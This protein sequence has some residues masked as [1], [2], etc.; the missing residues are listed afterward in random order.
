MTP[1]WTGAGPLGGVTQAAADRLMTF[2]F[3]IPKPVQE[4]RPIHFGIAPESTA[5]GKSA[6]TI[7]RHGLGGLIKT[8]DEEVRVSQD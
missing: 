7:S 6:G 1:I 4:P 5:N 2:T 3:E 8:I